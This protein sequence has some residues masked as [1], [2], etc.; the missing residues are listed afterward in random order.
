MTLEQ[1]HRLVKCEGKVHMYL[2]TLE[3]ISGTVQQMQ[4]QSAST[5]LSETVT[6]RPKQNSKNLCVYSCKVSTHIWGPSVSSETE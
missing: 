5:K 6:R 3:T 4:L 2:Y 1:Q